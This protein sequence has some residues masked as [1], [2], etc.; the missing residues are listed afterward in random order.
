MKKTLGIIGMG[1]LSLG[2]LAA[3]GNGE[4]SSNKDQTEISMF[5]S[6]VEYKNEMTQLVEDYQNEHDDVKINLTFVGG[7]EDSGAALKSKFASGEA[8]TIFMSA[9][10]N[11]F[12]EYKKYAADLSDT[13]SIKNA[14]PGT[15]DAFKLD[16]GGVGAMPMSYEVYSFLYNKTVFKEAGIDPSTIDDQAKLRAAVEKIDKNKEKLGLEAV[17][18]YPAKE[19]WSTGMHGA[20]AFYSLDFDNDPVAAF[21]A[22]Q[23]DFKYG[24]QLKEFVDIQNDYSVQP[25]TSL[26]YSTQIEDK[27]V[28][29][30]VAIVMQGSWVVPTL[31]TND[32][33]F[34]QEE[35]GI[36]PIPI[37]GVEYGKVD[38]GALNNYVVNKESGEKEVQA[39]KDFLDYMNTSEKGK[40]V[41]VDEFMFIPAYKGY[42]DYQSDINLI[43]EYTEYTNNNL[44]RISTFPSIKGDW[45]QF[46]VGTNIQ[47]YVSGEM[48]WKE[49]IK[50]S[51]DKWSVNN[52][53]K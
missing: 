22:E 19:T 42:E 38:G 49:L 8:P 26:D 3:C 4:A 43:K 32:E 5:L 16:D 18:A 1:L 24:N 28:G 6:K 17:F 21:D 36:L 10:I 50:D 25:T 46:T 13:E 45:T 44:V 41:V 33:E 20:S 23:V 37:D 31:M 35:V 12:V 11:D 15:T 40:Q 14:L 7:G 30:K 47:K 34:A 29:R 53:E 39:A 48:T 52:P 27:F 51:Q 2:L 9:G